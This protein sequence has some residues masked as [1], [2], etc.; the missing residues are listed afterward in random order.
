MAGHETDKVDSHRSE[1]DNSPDQ[2]EVPE[3]DW[4]K[5]PI[6]ELKNSTERGSTS[7]VAL[8]RLS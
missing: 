8:G 6:Y 1:H 4:E 7:I 3:L 2:G 5:P